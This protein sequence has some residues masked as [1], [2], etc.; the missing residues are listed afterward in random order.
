MPI[1]FV[2]LPP[3]LSEKLRQLVGQSSLWFEEDYFVC[4]FGAFQNARTVLW[5]LDCLD[6]TEVFVVDINYLY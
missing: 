3:I 5:L 6:N 4:E 1:H 2:N